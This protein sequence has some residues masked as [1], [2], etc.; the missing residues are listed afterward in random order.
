MYLLLANSFINVRICISMIFWLLVHRIW[1]SLL[2]R[3]IDKVERAL[4]TQQVH[5]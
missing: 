1:A 5:K 2:I 3:Y 4:T